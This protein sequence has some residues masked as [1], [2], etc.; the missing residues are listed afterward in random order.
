MK[1]RKVLKKQGQSGIKAVLA[2]L[3]LLTIGFHANAQSSA[4]VK[5]GLSAPYISPESFLVMDQGVPYYLVNV[6]HTNYGIHAGIFLQVQMGHFFIQPELL[7]NTSSNEYGIDSLYSPDAGKAHFTDTYRNL[8]LPFMLGFKAG[9]FRIGAGP[10]GHMFV[11]GESGFNG[12]EGFYA[13]YNSNKFSWGWQGGIG[14][15]FWKLHFDF[16][17]EKNNSPVGDYITFFGKPYDFAT[18]NDRFIGSVG[19]SF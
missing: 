18:D 15:D 10:V 12:Y 3:L 11:S 16:R 6:E 8:D 7:F 19:L 9:V 17:Y 5:F 2:F 1:K 14:L 4:G 13:D